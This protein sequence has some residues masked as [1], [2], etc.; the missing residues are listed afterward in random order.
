M[1][2]MNRAG[3]SD[4]VTLC[5]EFEAD[6]FGSHTEAPR[7]IV[8]DLV[9]P[10]LEESARLVARHRLGAYDA[11]MLGSA[12]AAREADPGCGT[13]ACFDLELRAA[14]EAEG[15]TLHPASVMS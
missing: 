2:R 1:V 8:V 10:V 9:P 14:A 7:F 15:F 3:D 6:Y 11:M 12:V 13:F 4:A 5:A